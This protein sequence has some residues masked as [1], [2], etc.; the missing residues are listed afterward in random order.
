[1]LSL[2]LISAAENYKN[3]AKKEETAADTGADI[4][5]E[6]KAEIEQLIADRAAAKKAKNYAEADR[7]RNYLLEKGVTLVDTSAG[8]QYKIG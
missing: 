8:T 6:F 5:P 7:I 3:A 4:D 2:D 1:M